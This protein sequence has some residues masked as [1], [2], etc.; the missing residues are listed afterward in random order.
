MKVQNT[1]AVRAS[2]SFPPEIYETLETINE[3]K[4]SVAGLGS[5]R[6]AG[7]IHRGKMAAVRT[8]GIAEG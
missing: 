8:D 6:G 2:I 7:E 1:P 4:Q 3:G 5:A